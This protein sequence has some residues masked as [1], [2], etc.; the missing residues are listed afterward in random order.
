[1]PPS[2]ASLP[3][4]PCAVIRLGSTRLPIGLQHIGPITRIDRVIIVRGSAS[5]C[6]AQLLPVE[7]N[8]AINGSY[9]VGE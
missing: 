3:A 4:P 2:M 8:W 5:K 6:R 7:L 9:D 1:M